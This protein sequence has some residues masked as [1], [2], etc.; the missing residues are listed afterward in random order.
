MSDTIID[1]MCAAADDACRV[2][3]VPIIELLLLQHQV[4][5]GDVDAQCVAQIAIAMMQEVSNAPPDQP[6]TC[7]CCPQPIRRGDCFH[8]GAI[9]PAVGEPTPGRGFLICDQCS[10]A[11]E[12][13]DSAVAQVLRASDP[14]AR[15]SRGGGWGGL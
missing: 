13:L 14:P 4:A 7:A 1:A 10:P 3:V 15:T 5:R 12:R 11:S 9:L 2:V 8:I 6:A